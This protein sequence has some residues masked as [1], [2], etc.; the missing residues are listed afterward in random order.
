MSTVK[1]Y[2]DALRKHNA[3]HCVKLTGTQSQLAQ[4]ARDK[5]ILARLK[6]K[7]STKKKQSTY[8]AP[9]SHFEEITSAGATAYTRFRALPCA[10]L[11][12]TNCGLQELL[13][14]HK[15]AIS[16]NVG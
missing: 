1:K 16:R 4:R 8:V 13:E 10:L 11:L 14:L 6:H 7:S 5:N 2:K 15:G 9:S 12:A 3:K